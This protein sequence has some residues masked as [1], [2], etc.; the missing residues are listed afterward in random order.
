MKKLLFA[1][2]L[3]LLLAAACNSSK[4]IS[5]NQT[6]TQTN[7]SPTSVNQNIGGP[8]SP[9]STSSTKPT[10]AGS[11]S[12]FDNP[13]FDVNSLSTITAIPSVDTSTW[14]TYT[15]TKLGFQFKYPVDWIIDNLDDTDSINNLYIKKANYNYDVGDGDAQ[16]E[17]IIGLMARPQNQAPTN[18]LG[19]LQLFNSERG[20]GWQSS[21]ISGFKSEVI[22]GQNTYH[23]THPSEPAP[24]SDETFFYHN[25]YEFVVSGDSLPNDVYKDGITGLKVMEIARG[26][27]TTLKFTK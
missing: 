16:A 23:I 26:V 12:P 22:N 18:A 17:P 7:Q 10:T 27:V 19:F 3:I 9:D 6:P 24:P 13:N 11:T 4:Q 21:D 1:V 20:G 2:P 8:V 5:S 15:N 14:K 25:N